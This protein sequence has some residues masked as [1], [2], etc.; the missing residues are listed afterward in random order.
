MQL[1]EKNPNISLSTKHA[2]KPPSG[3]DPPFSG[4]W[5]SSPAPEM[6]FLSSFIYGCSSWWFLGCSPATSLSH[7]VHARLRNK[8]RWGNGGVVLCGERTVPTSFEVSDIPSPLHIGLPTK[9]WL[10]RG[11]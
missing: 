2:A 9:V 5:R 10:R 11:V 4:V 8:E 6:I 3:L 7:Q 1:E